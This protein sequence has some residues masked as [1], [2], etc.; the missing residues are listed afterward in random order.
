M[1]SYQEPRSITGERAAVLLYHAQNERLLEA[2]KAGSSL[3]VSGG[4]LSGEAVALLAHR[5]AQPFRSWEAEDVTTR[6][7]WRGEVARID[8][9]LAE[10]F[11]E[12][13]S[14]DAWPV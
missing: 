10:E 3:G 5:V 2:A 13:V 9:K 8:A 14:A 7:F 11:P 12:E 4:L 6:D 1:P